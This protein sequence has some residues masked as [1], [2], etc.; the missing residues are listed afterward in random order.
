MYIL[1]QYILRERLYNRVEGYEA[2]TRDDWSKKF[3]LESRYTGTSSKFPLPR[4][5][6]ISM[7]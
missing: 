2:M 3:C 1:V 6:S 4:I 5:K 7:G